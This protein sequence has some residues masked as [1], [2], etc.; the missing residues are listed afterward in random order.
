[1][2]MPWPPPT[3][4][5]ST[6]I[7]LSSVSQVVEQRVHDPRAGHPV[8]MAEGDRAA[9]RVQLVAERVDAELAADGKYLRRERLVQLDDVDLVDRHPGL[10]QR[11][12]HR[13]DRAD[14]HD[15]GC[16]ARRPTRR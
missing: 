4:I 14:A 8:G 10:L 7:V 13:L 11:H 6:P 9:V 15:L 12:A 3:H 1:M 5:V 2:A 16:D